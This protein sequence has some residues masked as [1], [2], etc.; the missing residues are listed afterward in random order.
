MVFFLWSSQLAEIKEWVTLDIRYNTIFTACKGK[1]LLTIQRGDS[2]V[3]MAILDK[4]QT[5]NNT[6]THTYQLKVGLSIL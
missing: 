6:R 2:E 3:L 4:K 1:Q 5:I